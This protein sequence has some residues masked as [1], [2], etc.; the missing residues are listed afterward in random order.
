MSTSPEQDNENDFLN[1]KTP[2]NIPNNLIVGA[3]FSAIVAALTLIGSAIYLL[4]FYK[5]K[6]DTIEEAQKELNIKIDKLGEKFV[7]MDKSTTKIG[8]DLEN[9]KSNTNVSK[10]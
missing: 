5:N 8:S 3:I 1:K 2:F 10:N 4:G 9:L 6:I 7:E